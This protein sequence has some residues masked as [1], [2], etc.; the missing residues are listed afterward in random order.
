V[1]ARDRKVL[2]THSPE[3]SKTLQQSTELIS[4]PASAT[5]EAVAVS[6]S[7]STS[8]PT[9]VV[10][11]LKY[12]MCKNWR[13]RGAC[14]YGDKCLFAHG[15]KELTKRSTAP[16][17]ETPTESKTEEKKVESSP[18][19]SV[20]KEEA[21]LSTDDKELPLSPEKI[22]SANEESKDSDKS[23]EP[24][25]MKLEKVEAFCE[26]PGKSGSESE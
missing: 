4:T 17:V 16:P 7:A 21:S 9:T 14:K 11:R 19:Q 10:R 6:S 13:E 8:S 18:I 5:S 23:S 12:E 25:V 3:A 24:T 2:G 15:D 1:Q 22:S 20:Q 26:T